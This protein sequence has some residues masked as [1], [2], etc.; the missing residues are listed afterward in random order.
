MAVLRPN[1]PGGPCA[2]AGEVHHGALGL[3]SRVFRKA[4]VAGPT[5]AE[6]T[7]AAARATLGSLERNLELREIIGCPGA[8]VKRRKKGTSGLGQHI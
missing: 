7:A 8:E 2:R 6:G 1:R 5:A 3:E 4:E